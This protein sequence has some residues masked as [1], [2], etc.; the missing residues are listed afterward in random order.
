MMGSNGRDTMTDADAI[1]LMVRDSHTS[2]VKTFN[3]H[4]PT[5]LDDVQTRAMVTAARVLVVDDSQMD[6]DMTILQ[7]GRAWPFKRP[8]LVECAASGRV[9][10]EKTRNTLFALALLDWNMPDVSGLDVLLEVRKGGQRLPV[11][12]VSGL[13]REEIGADL[14]ALGASFVYKEELDP[15]H[16]CNAITAALDFHREAP[17][18]L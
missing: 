8:M 15:V 3:A 12:V 7:L 16:F 18:L 5:R 6:R 14:N 10:L 17:T 9:A 13:T 4:N 2:A 11:V 1:V